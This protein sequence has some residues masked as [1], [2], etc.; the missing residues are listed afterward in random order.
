MLEARA[1]LHNLDLAY[2]T[3]L[4]LK[5]EPKGEYQIHDKI[6]KSKTGESLNE[7][8]LRLRHV[9]KNIWSEKP[10]IVA[11]KKTELKSIGKNSI[12][13]IKEQFDTLEAAE[14]YIA[15]NYAD[16]FEFDFEFDRTGWQ[17]DIGK[18]QVD[19]EDIEG[20]YSIECKSETEE[21]LKALCA[22][23]VCDDAI[24]EGPSVTAVKEILGR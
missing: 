9:S 8:F 24:I 7:V 17:Y 10:F 12:I 6:F 22:Y 1:F 11:I 14:K 5:A 19:L 21:G 3:L 15:E 18:D 2:K 20:N 4:T 13:P 23:F 16:Q